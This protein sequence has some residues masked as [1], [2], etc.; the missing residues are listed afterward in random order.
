M[1]KVTFGASDRKL[2]EGPSHWFFSFIA[3]AANTWEKA[4]EKRKE[5]ENV[6]KGL[7]NETTCEMY[8]FIAWVFKER[9]SPGRVN[10][11]HLLGPF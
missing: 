2:R 3:V 7:C 9:S 4:K 10:T 8:H 11:F 1:H 5:R 6:I